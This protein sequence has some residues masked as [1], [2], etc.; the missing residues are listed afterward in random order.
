MQHN[1]NVTWAYPCKCLTFGCIATTGVSNFRLHSNGGIRPNKSHYISLPWKLSSDICDFFCH[2]TPS[3]MRGWICNLQL[4]LGLAN[5]VFLAS[6]LNFET[7]SSYCNYFPQE[8]DGPAI[9]PGTG[10]VWFIDM[11]HDISMFMYM[12]YIC[13]AS[14]NLGSLQPL[15]LYQLLLPL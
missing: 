14:F 1:S 7:P 8:K 3:L 6:C 5:V 4:L 13:L 9:L 10:F 15:M 12:Q 2:G 11:L